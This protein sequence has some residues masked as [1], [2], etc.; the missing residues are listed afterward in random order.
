IY[1]F[2]NEELLEEKRSQMSEYAFRCQYYNNVITDVERVFPTHLIKSYDKLEGKIEDYEWILTIDPSFSD[3]K[4]SDNIGFVLCGY[5]KNNNVWVEK[6]VRYKL[7]VVELLHK[8]YEYNSIYPITNV[9]IEKGTWQG[10]LQDMFNYIIAQEGLPMIPIS[11][12]NLSYEPNAK[13][14]RIMALTGYFEKGIIHLKSDVYDE[15][16]GE[17]KE[18]NTYDLKQEMYYFST[19]SRQKNDVLD[20]LSMQPKCHIWGNEYRGDS[21]RFKTG[22]STYRDA[23]YGY[24]K[25]SMEYGF[26]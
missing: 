26:Y 5:D 13:N 25:K 18:K 3:S 19:S 14:N 12:I 15:D 21:S 10:A 2:Y 23:L 16:S 7:S 20:A 8:I 9:G 22:V 17:I 4:K 6:A 1:S 11:D 24:K